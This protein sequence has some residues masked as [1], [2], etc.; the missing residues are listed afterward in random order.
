M[1]GNAMF[2]NPM[3]SDIEVQMQCLCKRLM[4]TMTHIYK[5]TMLLHN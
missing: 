3:K 5:H 1:T 2:L 4:E